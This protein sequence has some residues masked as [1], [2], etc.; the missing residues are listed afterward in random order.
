MMMNNDELSLNYPADQ[1]A[2]HYRQQL[3]AMLDGDLAQDQA[4]FMLRRLQHDRELAGCWERWQVCGEIM[5]GSHTGLLDNSFTQR[6]ALAIAAEGQSV[7]TLQQ[8][9]ITHSRARWFGGSVALVASFAAAVFLIGKQPVQAPQPILSANTPAVEIQQS[10]P[11]ERTPSQQSAV[12]GVAAPVAAEQ[13]ATVTAADAGSNIV[14]MSSDQIAAGNQA[15]AIASTAI[16]AAASA[17]ST[18]SQAQRRAI[19]RQQAEVKKQ[20]V[21]D[22]SEATFLASVPTKATPHSATDTQVADNTAATKYFMALPSA[23]AAQEQ[24]WP[25][26]KLI[27]N[28]FAAN[29]YAASARLEYSAANQNISEISQSTAAPVL[30]QSASVDG[31]I[32]P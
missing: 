8:Q 13:A 5:R 15:P 32:I 20:S 12:S 7:P 14:E 31:S 19:R 9:P 17:R 18:R 27:N 23:S 6:V 22:I 16:A 30:E 21:N 3:S 4:K 29:P 26:A 24:P 25:R 28:Q 1:L 2:K 10:S 11:V